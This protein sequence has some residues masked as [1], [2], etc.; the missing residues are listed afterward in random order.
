MSYSGKQRSGGSSFCFFGEGGNSFLKRKFCLH[1]VLPWLQHVA[2]D[3]PGTLTGFCCLYQHRVVSR[4]KDLNK[5]W[6]NI[7][8]T[9]FLPFSFFFLEGFGE[10]LSFLPPSYLL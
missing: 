10:A 7:F 1:D 6:I 9:L 8:F 5:N 4:G 2:P 3:L